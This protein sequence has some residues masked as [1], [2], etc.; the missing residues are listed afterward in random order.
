MLVLMLSHCCQVE[1]VIVIVMSTAKLRKMEG[2][3]VRV[4]QVVVR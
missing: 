1:V 2:V 4:C 3:R